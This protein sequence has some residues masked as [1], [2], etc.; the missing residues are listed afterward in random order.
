MKRLTGG[1]ECD[2]FSFTLDERHLVLK[3]FVEGD[4]RC[5]AE[6]ENLGVV[7]TASVSTPEPVGLD[8]EGHWYGT[9][10]LVM[11]ALRGAPE[12]HPSAINRW[13]RGA[14][15][16]LASIHQIDPTTSIQLRTPRWQRWKPPVEDMG[17]AAP[18]T[19]H[20]LALLYD[21]IERTPTVFSHD[22]F[23]PGNLLFVDG[24][25]SG[26]VDWSDVVIEPRQAA[27]ALYRHMLALHPGG[28]AS[29]MFSDHYESITGIS[30]DDMALW[31]VLYG[32]R[33]VQPVKH[34]ARAFRGL[35]VTITSEQINS[36]S[37]RWVEAALDK[38]DLGTA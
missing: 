31:D 29:D 10:A 34:W 4:T 27:V 11:S 28:Q 21:R 37:R 12:L 2:T 38:I 32:L 35:G 22:D 19:E 15:A 13:T 24:E 26:V 8:H 33:G 7:A 5:R 23:N 14:A 3:I 36:R 1:L 25:L 16:A 9:P 18:N 17:V 20:A 30:F 6:Y